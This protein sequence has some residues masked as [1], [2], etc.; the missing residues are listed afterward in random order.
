MKKSIKKIKLKM[1][2]TL[3]ILLL[4]SLLFSCQKK[5]IIPK[6]VEKQ[7]QENRSAETADFI[8]HPYLYEDEPNILELELDLL[9]PLFQ[10][11]RDGGKGI[12]DLF[13]YISINGQTPQI[14]KFR[15]DY[16]LKKAYFNLS[17]NW[18]LINPNF[19]LKIW[20]QES[21]DAP[22]YS[23]ETWMGDG[24]NRRYNRNCK[25]FSNIKRQSDL[26]E[27][28]PF[29]LA[30]VGKNAQ[31]WVNHIA[32]VGKG[33]SFVPVYMKCFKY[34]ESLDLGLNQI[35]TIPEEIWNL[36]DMLYLSFS[37][38]Q[39]TN[40]SA[41]IEKLNKL[42]ILNL[43]ANQIGSL[44]NTV[45]GLIELK[46]LQIAGNKLT[47]LPSLSKL[48]KLEI[49]HASNNKLKY[50]F[51]VGLSGVGTITYLSSLSELYL[52]N[53][54]LYYYP[55]MLGGHKL[56]KLKILDIS[57]NGTWILG[58]KI[59]HFTALENLNASG[60]NFAAVNNV[61]TIHPEIGQ[62]YNLKK[63]NLSNCGLE[64]LPSEIAG[65][66]NLEELNLSYN[67]IPIE[68]IPLCSYP[69]L[70]NLKLWET[71]IKGLPL[72][73]TNL[74]DLEVFHLLSRKL[75]SLPYNFTSLKKIREIQIHLPPVVWALAPGVPLLPGNFSKALREAYPFIIFH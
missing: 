68:K 10:T 38:N 44:P 72:C 54:A 19:N 25:E 52:A 59:H 75:E 57:N 28:W 8:L 23:A 31:G 67:T 43:N 74:K 36:K 65:L 30:N 69:K 6:V 26:L 22:I 55:G 27:T 13:L 53:N 15:P 50:S 20:H 47:A 33:L 64:T 42:N 62:L 16:Q 37:N 35:K 46:N 29:N 51:L 56:T 7:A 49:L 63:L 58:N 48:Q 11:P 70:K 73:F 18:N 40:L 12:G 17:I 14:Q 21:P 9:H 2:N 32:L 61:K 39:L 41:N 3:Y 1:K 5:K 45:G 34:L 4:I 66:S 71:S 60:N 24:V